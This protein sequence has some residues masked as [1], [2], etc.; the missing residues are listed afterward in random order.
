MLDRREALELFDYDRWAG[1]RCVRALEGLASPSAEVMRL[2]THVVISLETWFERVIAAQPPRTDFWPTGL[3]LATLARRLEGAQRAWRMHLERL[4]ADG[5]AR[6]VRF[7]N[8]KGEECADPLEAIVRHVVN[9]GT[10]HRAQVASLLRAAGHTPPALDF[11]VWRR[12][13]AK[14]APPVEPRPWKHFVIAS[15]YL[16]PLTE[17]DRLLA[18]HRAHL[19]TGY[20]RGLLLASGPQNPRIGGMILARAHE[21]AELELFLAEDPF[22]KAGIARYHLVEFDPVKRSDAFTAWIATPAPG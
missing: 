11:I 19:G 10:H 3:D 17:I 2:W 12:E 4:E 6:V 7:K 8:S 5:F 16:A 9:H 1:L 20:A 15:D 18:E 13:L 14:T 22:A 21:R